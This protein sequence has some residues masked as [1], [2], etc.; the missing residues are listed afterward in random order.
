VEEVKDEVVEEH[1][2]EQEAAMAEV[3]VAPVEVQTVVDAPVGVA[4]E[5]EQAVVEPEAATLSSSLADM[6]LSNRTP[7]T[8][9]EVEA[10]APLL[11]EGV[12][13][14]QGAPVA[15]D[16]VEMSPTDGKVNSISALSS[17]SIEHT[18]APCAEA[19]VSETTMTPSME[20]E[21]AST[22]MQVAP[23]LEL[24]LP[25]E[26]VPTEPTMT[27]EP[28]P[29]ETSLVPVMEAPLTA[30]TPAETPATIEPVPSDTPVE[31]EQATQQKDNRPLPQPAR[32]NKRKG[33]S[34]EQKPHTTSAAT[35][36]IFHKTQSKATSSAKTDEAAKSTSA[37]SKDDPESQTQSRPAK[38]K[39][40]ASD[41]NPPPAPLSAAAKDIRPKRLV[42]RSSSGSTLSKART[43][44]EQNAKSAVAS[45][46]ANE[47][48]KDS[49]MNPTASSLARATAAEA[50]K[51]LLKGT[52]AKKTPARKPT[53]SKILAKSAARGPSAPS[54]Q[55][56]SITALPAPAAVEEEEDSLRNVKRR[57]N[58]TDA[59][60]AS[61]RLY[62]DA[63]EGKAR[64]DARRAELQETYT[65]APQVNN[66]KRRSPPGD[67]EESSQDHFTRLHAQAKELLEKKREL[68]QQHERDGC[69]FAPTISARAKR[70]A[71]PSSGPRYENLYKH[72]QEMKQKREEKLMEKAKTTEEQCPFKPKITASKSPVKTKPLYDSEREKQKRLALEQKK[73]EAEMSECT[74]KP[75]VS[76]K[77][78]K[79][80]T[81][82]PS[83]A[84]T[85]AA[86]DANPYNRL[87]QASI[88]RA[89]R[90]QKMRQERDEEEKAQAPFQPKI[91]ARS[92]MLKAKTKSKEP[93]HK[94][95][96]NKDYMKKV[97]AEREQRRLE[98]EQQFTF[99]VRWF[100]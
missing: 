17:E 19:A 80:K 36:R 64:K 59:N 83:D 77:R 23:P 13:K 14:Q 97:D 94:R 46:P 79:G 52:A 58:A 68:Q 73:I 25:T 65:F 86:T 51:A 40:D 63:K 35:S 32:R 47:L 1:F 71:Q 98:E 16:H 50:R 15:D 75:K 12:H 56:K 38:R 69:T 7:N 31:A 48:K 45:H 72:A 66:S 57:L 37:A 99:K 93:F 42:A 30:P 81:E 70:L 18:P 34:P 27:S 29:A 53:R 9:A 3:E 78:L 92:R 21:A 90:L 28:S 5:T 62:D 44:T 61:T 85:G 24:P 55:D 60:A 76:T 20:I 84:P 33:D 11:A 95:L 54:E 39:G 96:Y 41:A 10:E 49:M 89:E 87:Y 26:Q 4:Q 67:T 8:N 91:T 82:E 22:E 2:E 43:D 88:E 100:S 74:F 6:N